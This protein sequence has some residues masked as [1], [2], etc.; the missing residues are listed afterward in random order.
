M[1]FETCGVS[2]D[3]FSFF[4]FFTMADFQ[5]HLSKATY[6]GESHE[7]CQGNAIFLL[8]R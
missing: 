8:Q 3:L 1:M 4:F 6:H 2:H 5:L 7:T